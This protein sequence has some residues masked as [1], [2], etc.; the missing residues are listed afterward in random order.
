MGKR[1]MN[2]FQRAP[3]LMP[4]SPIAVEGEP[5]EGD[6]LEADVPPGDATAAAANLRIVCQTER[7]AW[8]VLAPGCVK[9]SAVCGTRAQA[10]ARAIEILRRCGGGE[11]RVHAV[12]ETLITSR[13]VGPAAPLP[14]RRSIQRAPRGSFSL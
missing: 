5:L 13:S 12:D 7:G 8:R 6:E 11:L 14:K 2:T 1:P 4:P 9:A 3:W 10:V